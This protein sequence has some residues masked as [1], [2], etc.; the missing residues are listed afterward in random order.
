[1]NAQRADVVITGGGLAGLSLALQLRQR[2]PE[3]AI[4][5]LERRA[6]PVREAAFKVGESTVEIGAHYFAEVLGL[7]EHLETEQIRKFGFRFFFSDKREDI[8][9]CTELGVSQILPTPSWQIDRGRFENF[10][11]ERARAQGIT[12]VDSCSVKGVDLSDDQA[13]HAVRYERA[14]EAGTLSARW[15]V[16]ASGRAGLL[17]RKLGLTQDNA[18]DANAVWWRVEGLIDP[19]GWSQDSS[20]LQRCTPPDRWRSTNHMCGPGYWF[21]LIPLSSGAH[22]LGIVCDASMHPLD[23][24][25]THDKA[26]TWLRTHQPQVA[27]TL[28]K[29]DYRLQDF[30]FLRNFSYGCKQVFSPQRW[31]LTGE[32][33]LFLDPFYS[34]GSD[35][36]AI[37]NTYIC[38]LIGRDRAGRSL[39]PYVELYQQLYFSFYENTL[40]LYQDQYALFG[41]AQVMPVKVIW[42]YTYYWSLLA[43]LFCSGRIADLS[44]LSRMKS[45]FFYARD[46]NLAMQRVLHDWGQHNT[47]QGLAT[48][49]GRLLDQYLIG[50]F[51]ELNGALNDTLDDDAFAARIHS[52]VA[53]MAVLA[54]EILQQARQRHAALPDHGLDALT[55]NAIGEPILTAAW[56]AD[57]A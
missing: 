34:P 21:W 53:Q 7:R 56:Y 38:E 3:L 42:D 24:M 15:V 57:A 30:L 18:H 48:D 37:S 41:D 45:D 27:A 29:A 17:K 33:G 16:D 47:A 46:M 43:P 12:F 8:D 1:M 31:A 50:W 39:S 19:N 40:T 51:N 22:S 20:W 23:T 36:I 49:D 32:A 9:R 11:G 4:T 10:L 6:H 2:D 14:G 35:F 25:N 54:R 44:L 26:M 52:N 55:A 13:D 28:D 5:V